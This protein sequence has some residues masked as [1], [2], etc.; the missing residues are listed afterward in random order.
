MTTITHEHRCSDCG[1]SINLGLVASIIDARGVEHYPVY[2][3]D[4]CIERSNTEAAGGDPDD[5]DSE[6]PF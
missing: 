4:Q 5:L 2:M 3:C 6:I 1:S